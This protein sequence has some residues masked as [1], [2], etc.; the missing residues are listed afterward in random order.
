LAIF[1]Q[2]RQQL[3]VWFDARRQID[4]NMQ[5]LLVSKAAPQI[6]D[7]LTTC[8]RRYRLISVNEDMYEVFSPEPVHNYIVQRV[9][10]TCS[11]F[12][13]QNT[14]IPCGHAL[15]V[16]LKVKEEP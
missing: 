13:W 4:V 8:A 14:G 1:E 10:G 9:A 16:S 12:E 7:V 15:A 11:C 5:G 2:I 6:R 3:T